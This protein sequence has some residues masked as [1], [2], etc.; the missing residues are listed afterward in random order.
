M[1]W[2]QAKACNLNPLK[3]MATKRVNTLPTPPAVQAMVDALTTQ[4]PEGHWAA[5]HGLGAYSNQW[6]VFSEVLRARIDELKQAGEV[7]RGGYRVGIRVIL[8]A[9]SIHTAYF[10]F[11]CEAAHRRLKANFRPEMLDG[12]LAYSGDGEVWCYGVKM[13]NGKNRRQHVLAK[14]QPA[15]AIQG[16]LNDPSF[17]SVGTPQERLFELEVGSYQFETEAALIAKADRLAAAYLPFLKAI[18]PL[19]GE[20]IS[21]KR[22]T[23][24]DPLR[25]NLPKV[26]GPVSQCSCEHRK[27]DG[28]DSRLACAGRLEAAHI[29]PYQQGGSGDASNGLWLCHVHHCETEGRIEGNRLSVRLLEHVAVTRRSALA[30]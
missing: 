8:D 26:T 27:I 29:R 15:E 10:Q 11:D 12:L 18:L 25:R 13:K 16:W 19:E 7:T 5:S 1:I 22:L 9:D 30:R 14:T 2:G 17:Y 4:C 24:Q 20:P 21:A 6:M 28:L 3:A 23:R